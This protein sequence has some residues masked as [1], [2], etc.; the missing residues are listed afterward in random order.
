MAVISSITKKVSTWSS[1]RAELLSG[2]GA[3]D[4]VDFWGKNICKNLCREKTMYILFN[5]LSDIK[6]P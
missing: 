1:T 5:S 4:I 2:R 6:T 3:I